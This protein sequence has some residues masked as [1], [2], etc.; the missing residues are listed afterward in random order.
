MITK[1]ETL[2]EQIDKLQAEKEML[3]NM[4][5]THDKCPR[6]CNTYLS[7]SSEEDTSIQNEED[8]LDPNEL[9][10]EVEFVIDSSDSVSPFSAAL[11]NEVI[12]EPLLPE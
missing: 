9:N 2:K 6:T 1:N 12:E 5:K 10:I 11:V 3:C 7:T 8:V 4:V